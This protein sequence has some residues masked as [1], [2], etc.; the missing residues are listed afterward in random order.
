MEF[1][2]RRVLI[3]VAC[4]G[5]AAALWYAKRRYDFQQRYHA[6]L[7]AT[8]YYFP[9]EVDWGPLETLK[10]QLDGQDVIGGELTLVSGSTVPV[11]AEATF[12]DPGP[13]GTS[14]CLAITNRP[15]IDGE[16]DWSDLRIAGEWR[17]YLE[18]R[19]PHTQ[20]IDVPSGDYELRIFMRVEYLPAVQPEIKVYKLGE[21]I[22]HVVE[23][24]SH[25]EADSP[26][27]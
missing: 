3:V 15:I 27:Q 14:H 17:T 16:T 22:A 20:S 7:V 26:P 11:I 12:S 8:G 10:F 23:G 5:L 9:E 2:L 13:P 24:P 21:A 19:P 18:N 1:T 4:I 25:T 6:S